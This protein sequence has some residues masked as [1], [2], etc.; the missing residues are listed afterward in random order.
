MNVC[1][2]VASVPGPVVEEGTL[3]PLPPNPCV[4]TPCGPN[5][6]CQ[7]VSGQ[8]QCGCQA[9]MIGSAPNCRPECSISSDCPSNQACINQKCIDP[10]PGSCASNAEC[11]VVSH[12]PVCSCLTGY[13]GNGFDEC[14]PVPVVGKISV[15]LPSRFSSFGLWVIWLS[16]INSS[17]SSSFHSLS[18]FILPSLMSGSFTFFS[19]NDRL[20]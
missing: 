2:C 5:S 4:P 7:V 11:R 17:S 9:N 19:F 12:R 14:R 1:D 20:V 3:R 6:V 18:P 16:A 13:S 10:C 8:A 15:L